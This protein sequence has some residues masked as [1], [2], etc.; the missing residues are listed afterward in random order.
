MLDSNSAVLFLSVFHQ[1]IKHFLLLFKIKLLILQ[2][3]DKGTKFMSNFNRIS[4]NS[5][6]HRDDDDIF[7]VCFFVQEWMIATVNVVIVAVIIFH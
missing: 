1:A 5:D 3:Q 7:A 2:V 6:I 4:V